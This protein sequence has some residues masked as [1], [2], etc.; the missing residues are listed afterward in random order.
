MATCA[1]NS[2][3]YGRSPEYHA[4]IGGSHVTSANATNACP[5]TRARNN[6]VSTYRTQTSRRR[7]T[8]G[9][10][11]LSGIGHAR[12]L[13]LQATVRIPL[14]RDRLPLVLQLAPSLRELAPTQA[15]GPA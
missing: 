2:H 1:G 4:A 13:D 3:G 11:S 10:T 14:V 7:W 6:A 12:P 8:S 9:M 15:L 5:T